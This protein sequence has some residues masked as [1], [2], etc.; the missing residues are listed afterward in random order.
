MFLHNHRILN[1]KDLIIQ[2]MNL[3]QIEAFN[4]NNNNSSSNNNN[5]NN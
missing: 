2:V 1:I 3:N 4:N 5:N